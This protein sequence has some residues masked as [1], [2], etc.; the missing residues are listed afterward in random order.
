MITY[1]VYSGDDFSNKMTIF[2]MT[3]MAM[4]LVIRRRYLYDDDGDDC[5]NSMMVFIVRRWR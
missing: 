4:I 1:D 5:S 3:T 2:I